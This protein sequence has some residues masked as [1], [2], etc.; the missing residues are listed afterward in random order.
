[1]PHQNHRRSAKGP[2]WRWQTALSLHECQTPKVPR[3]I[4][5]TIKE[6]LAFLRT[7][8][9]SSHIARA[10]ELWN[11]EPKQESL[12]L[13]A[14]GGYSPTE[15]AQQLGAK[16][17]V[18]ERCL[19]LFFDI[20]PLRHAKAWIRAHII[21]PEESGGD[22]MRAVRYRLAYVGGREITRMLLVDQADLPFDR[23]DQ[24]FNRG[25]RWELKIQEALAM[26]T[27]DPIKLI[28][29]WLD[30]KKAMARIELE[31]KRLE[32]QCQEAER[33]H[34]V[35]LYQQEKAKSKA[36][37]EEQKVR[38][39][40][41]LA[42]QKQAALEFQRHQFAERILAEKEDAKVRLAAS[43]LAQLTW[44]RAQQT[45]EPLTDQDLVAAGTELEI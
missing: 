22:F 13:M 38:Q 25:L 35:R 6:A 39:R 18:I 26:P 24:L 40:R 3:G 17:Q 21:A 14:L 28:K 31:K 29:L 19:E 44:R 16:P 42:Q 8:D 30:Y 45:V 43:P 27:E 34:E 7:R 36:K 2:S 32:L 20:E 33:K 37:A 9:E 11:H 5:A 23:G 10:F 4:D 12:K 1:M 41:E 15:I